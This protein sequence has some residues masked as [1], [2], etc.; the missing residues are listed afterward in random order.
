MA[1]ADE[2]AAEVLEVLH[3]L[4]HQLNRRRHA[5]FV[6]GLVA[7]HALQVDGL[8]V[9]GDAAIGGA[10]LA[11]AEALGN[12]LIARL[13]DRD[14]VEV[15][16]LRRPELE[17]RHLQ[18]G[19]AV[20]ERDGLGHAT[21]EGDIGR[22]VRRRIRA[23]ELSFK[24][25]PSHLVVA[26]AHD[27][28]AELDRLRLDIEPHAVVESAEGIE[29]V[30]VPEEL[31]LRIVDDGVDGRNE[32]VLTRLERPSRE[33][34]PA[35]RK[36]AETDLAPVD[37]VLRAETAAIHHQKRVRRI[38]LQ[39]ETR[40]VESRTVLVEPAG[41]RVPTPR[42]DHL[43]VRREGRRHRSL[44]KRL[45]LFEAE[46]PKSVQFNLLHRGES[47][48]GENRRHECR[49][50]HGEQYTITDSGTEKGQPLMGE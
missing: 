38:V 28:A 19:T 23:H 7:V 16:G 49:C 17:V 3:V 27:D 5:E 1:A 40:P 6:V 24:L 2:V 45:P 41:H 47:A 20:L 31:D 13:P 8:S 14:R 32:L 9:E 34:E 22:E 33:L 18:R 35:P 29:V 46:I 50:P 44:L 42:H 26:R 15:R 25:N 21:I 37:P 12:C 30:E 10:N 48:R 11:N 39:R 4:V 43:V 36:F